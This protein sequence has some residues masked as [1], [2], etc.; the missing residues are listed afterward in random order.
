[1]KPDE[2]EDARKAEYYVSY[3]RALLSDNRETDAT[4]MFQ[5]ALARLAERTRMSC[6]TASFELYK[7]VRTRVSLLE[8]LYAA[9]EKS[10]LNVDGFFLLLK[11]MLMSVDNLNR[12]DFE[13]NVNLLMI[14]ALA[15]SEK[16]H[17]SHPPRQDGEAKRENDSVEVTADSPD[18]IISDCVKRGLS[19]E[20]LKHFVLSI[21]SLLDGKSNDAVIHASKSFELNKNDP[22]IGAYY[23]GSLIEN[24]QFE[25]AETLGTEMRVPNIRNIRTSAHPADAFIVSPK[26]I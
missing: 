20:F 14:Y 8:Y 11:L 2:L 22:L 3:Q 4:G 17:E 10:G 1:L 26:E 24:R 18:V 15:K 19:P 7:N 21:I 23:L 13:N 9:L 25:L 12:H 6:V 5:E 16:E